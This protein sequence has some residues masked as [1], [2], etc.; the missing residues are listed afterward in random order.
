MVIHWGVLPYCPS[1]QYPDQVSSATEVWLQSASKNHSKPCFHFSQGSGFNSTHLSKRLWSF[2][3]SNFTQA[4]LTLVYSTASELAWIM[5]LHF[6]KPVLP[7]W[8][9][10]KLQSCD[11]SQQISKWPMKYLILQYNI[12]SFPFFPRWYWQCLLNLPEELLK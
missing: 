4:S 7:E 8:A 6:S 12:R 2:S 1:K 3:L 11:L 9:V 10:R 5:L